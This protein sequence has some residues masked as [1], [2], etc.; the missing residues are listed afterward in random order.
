MPPRADGKVRGMWRL[1]VRS[2]RLAVG[3]PDYAAYVDHVHRA[4]PGRAPMP[5]AEFFR[6]RLQAR[7][8]RGRSRCC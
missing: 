6:N 1:L 4:H 5:E 7:Y 8:A 3:V 2:A